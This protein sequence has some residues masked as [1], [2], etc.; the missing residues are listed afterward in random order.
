MY[1]PGL[2]MELLK[3]QFQ[4]IKFYFIIWPKFKK[5]KNNPE[6]IPENSFRLDGMLR[7]WQHTE[8]GGSGGQNLGMHLYM[9]AGKARTS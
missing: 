5:K 4:L 1:F 2:G 7:E 9:D 8:G 3:I 6:A